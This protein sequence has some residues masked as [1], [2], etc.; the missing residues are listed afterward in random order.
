[1]T[2]PTTASRRDIFKGALGLGLAAAMP[3]IVPA[4]AQTAPAASDGIIR[5]TIGRTNEAIPALGLG[6][7]LTFDVLPG[8]KRDH[9]REVI[10]TYWD[11]GA[12]MIDTSPLYGTSENTVGD[13]ATDLG[14]NDQAFIANK[15]WATGEFLADQS[16]A[17][18]SL[19]QSQTR[20][21]RDRFDLMQCHSLVNVD[22]IVPLLNSWKKEG[23][24]R[25]VGVTHFENPYHPIL[26]DWIGK[27]PLDFVQVNYSIANRAAEDRIIPAA[28]DRGVA[29]MTNL[30]FEKA[31][32]FRLVEGRSVPDFAR[33]FGAEN[34]AQFFLK[35]VISNPNVTCALSS[36]ANPAHAAENIGAL[37]GPLPDAA[38]RRRMVQHMETIP[39]FNQ[40][41]TTPW[42]P[43]KRYPGIIARSQAELRARS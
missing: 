7:F 20:L 40:V 8:E 42:Y 10:R 24:V 30:P 36:T 38:M 22:F 33:E 34:W 6:T 23:R 13:F 31:R 29:V 26:V 15:I 43:G 16:Q 35:W 14:I 4:L 28:T 25:Y 5:R 3:G 41:A 2:Y 37:K 32:L 1:M 18:A 27:A 17:L 9:L 39:G 19:Q 21:W 11:G 12:R